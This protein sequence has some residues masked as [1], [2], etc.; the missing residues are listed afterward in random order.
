MPFYGP[1]GVCMAK[2][3]ENGAKRMLKMTPGS[4]KSIIGRPSIFDIPYVNL[5]DFRGP[6]GVWRETF[7]KCF[8]ECL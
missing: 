7:P 2:F 5:L 3:L 1:H 8:S 6:G 4:E